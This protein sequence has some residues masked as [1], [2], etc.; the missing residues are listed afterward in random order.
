MCH[1]SI[2][3]CNVLAANA[4]MPRI[5]F[6]KYFPKR[7]LDILFIHSNNITQEFVDQL[8]GRGRWDE[9]FASSLKLHPLGPNSVEDPV[10]QLNVE[11]PLPAKLELAR[12]FLR[13]F[14]QLSTNTK[15]VQGQYL[16]G[17][18]TIAV[19]RSKT[20]LRFFAINVSKAECVAK[21][22]KQSECRAL[23]ASE[24]DE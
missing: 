11:M 17:Y 23:I 3:C 15:P 2:Q 20:T 6:R 4:L 5:F 21:F 9:R 22:L 7:P 10:C 16:I 14:R 1:V 18:A 19:N 12:E 8:M 13:W 24:F